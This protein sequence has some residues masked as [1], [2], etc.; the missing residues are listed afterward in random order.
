M[1]GS[2]LCLE[3]GRSRIFDFKIFR[4]I[5]VQCT[6][7]DDSLPDID[8]EPPCKRQCQLGKILN[9][10][11]IYESVVNFFCVLHPRLSL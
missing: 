11:I 5:G 10:H 4:D 3:S 9:W 6:L 7:S 8:E 1:L 2:E